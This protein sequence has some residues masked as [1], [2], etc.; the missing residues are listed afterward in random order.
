MNRLHP[1]FSALLLAASFA[2]VSPAFA[3]SRSC[4]TAEE[5]VT[6]SAPLPDLAAALK[7]G[8]LNVLV[9]GSATIFGPEASLQPGT[10]T[11]QAGGN[12]APGGPAQVILAPAGPTSFPQQMADALRA[13]MPNL[14]VQVTLH[15]GRGLTAAEMLDLMRAD[16]AANRYQLVLWQTGTVEAVRNTPA[17]EFYQTLMD[18]ATLV[19]DKS[20]DLVLVD[21]QF[22]R[23]LHANA[24]LDPYAQGLQQ[25]AATPGVALFRR[26]DIMRA[27]AS[28]GQL[29]LERTPRGERR[30]AVQ[31]LHACLGQQLARLLLAASKL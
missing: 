2:V 24:N 28:E 10:V 12:T 14:Q 18:G 19:N 20:A 13:A 6:P 21:Q 17:G 26:F 31:A 27:W 11:S 1:A 25:V 23:F 22:S 7:N 8:K 4:N 29:D 16:L 15:G 30:A 9:V 5:L 3:G